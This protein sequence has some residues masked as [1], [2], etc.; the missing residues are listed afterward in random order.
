[1]S[2]GAPLINS[3]NPLRVT[4]HG[5]GTCS[6]DIEVEAVI[7]SGAL[8]T[9]ALQ[10]T[11]NNSLASIDT[12]TPSLGQALAS[13][14]TP[15]VVASNQ[16][17]AVSGSVG[18]TWSLSSSTDSVSAIAVQSGAW[19][20]GR[21][22]VASSATDSIA[23]SQSGVWNINNVSGVVS[24]P[25]GA[26]T[27]S[28]LLS[29]SGFSASINSKLNTLGQKTMANSTP[30]VISSD[31]TAVAVKGTNATGVAPTINPIYAAGIDVNG[32][33]R[34]LLV[35]EMGAIVTAS[36]HSS[37]TDIAPGQVTTAATTI[38]EVMKTA[39][40][41]QTAQ[42]QRSI[43][44]S[45]ANDT[46][47]GLG[48]RQITIYYIPLGGGPL[49]TE[50]IT[51]NGVTPV[52]TVNTDICYIEK[53][54]VTSWGLIAY[55]VGTINLFTGLAGAGTVFGSIAPQD[56]R[57]YWAHH[58]NVSGKITR[59]VSI[60]FGSDGN[61][62]GETDFFQLKVKHGF[63]G[64]VEVIENL[65]LG[66]T[67]SSTVTRLFSAPKSITTTA[68]RFFVTVTPGSVNAM[69]HNAT[70]DWVEI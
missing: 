21:T 13:G 42:A 12:K 50:V 62:A 48:A 39:Y 67:T 58:Y 45:D 57:T 61:A 56:N 27:E 55:N 52:N 37:S 3:G 14:S 36:I 38:V 4:E 40:V 53:M 7:D 17:L 11:G 15:V 33:V 59:I 8:A 34:P 54:E 19:T 1:M 35:N 2:V 30:I 32:L 9:S 6:L 60:S 26:S 41:E 49:K 66:G 63:L 25:T 65:R 68:A 28:T 5:D 18:R 22:W 64:K 51:L 16:T 29:V 31:Q 43:V 70:I 23:A 69:N 20:A 46:S 44:S 10:I 47:A 24:L